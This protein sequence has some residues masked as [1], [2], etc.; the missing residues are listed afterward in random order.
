MLIRMKSPSWNSR[1]HSSKGRTCTPDHLQRRSVM[2]T[3]AG[4]GL[5]THR[6]LSRAGPLRRAG[7]C[8]CARL[9]AHRRETEGDTSLSVS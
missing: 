8:S 9:R 6:G 3:L 5:A 2:R 7:R 4:L 1:Q